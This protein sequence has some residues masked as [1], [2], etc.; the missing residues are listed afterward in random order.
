ME[1]QHM[2]PATL[3]LSKA[4]QKCETGRSGPII[5]AHTLPPDMSLVLLEGRCKQ[6]QTFGHVECMGQHIAM[7]PTTDNVNSMIIEKYSH[8]LDDEMEEEYVHNET[9]I[10][11]IK[12]TKYE[13]VIPKEVADQQTHL[14]PVQR[15]VHLEKQHNTRPYDTKAYSVP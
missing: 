11:E 15:K 4:I 5:H 10:S 14:M 13:E 3:L 9:Y 6:M 12:D 7:L 1:E 8:L 2:M